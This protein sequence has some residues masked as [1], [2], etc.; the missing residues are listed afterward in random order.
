MAWKGN[1]KSDLMFM[2]INGY[3]RSRRPYNH[4]ICLATSEMSPRII[5][6]SVVVSRKQGPLPS[7]SFG[8]NQKRLRPRDF[9]RTQSVLSNARR[10]DDDEP[11]QDVALL[12][13]LDPVAKLYRRYAFHRAR[14]FDLNQEMR[15]VAAVRSFRS[16]IRGIR[17]ESHRCSYPYPL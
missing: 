16:E 2:N 8:D 6:E 4:Q 15:L 12:R 10:I 14:A 17:P 13:S 3:F 7:A 9:D 5:N 1:K 11:R